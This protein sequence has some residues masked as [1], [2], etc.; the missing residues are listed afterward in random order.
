MRMFSGFSE[1]TGGFLW[2]LAF[3]NERPWFLAHKQEFEDYV[4]IPFKMLASESF[5]LFTGRCPDFSGS[6]HVSRIYRDA[7]RLFGR[8]PYQDHLWFSVTD[9]AVIH[10]GPMLW[11]EIS[12][13]QY[14]YGMGWYGATP[15]Q[16]EAF[17]RSIDANP[18]RFR[19]LA[20]QL[21]RKGWLLSGESYKR[22]KALHD[23]ALIDSWYNRKYAGVHKEFNLGGDAY[24][25][26]L[27]GIVADA[28]QELLPMYRYLMEVYLSCPEEMTRER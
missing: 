23:D 9:S 24:T 26:A 28:F 8:G 20:Q 6:V 11:F 22:P 2:E 1:K 7:R 13:A 5:A 17:R 15:V 10:N 21:E 12:P 16:M 19:R 14:S 4:N 27:P 18:A 3:N 25:A